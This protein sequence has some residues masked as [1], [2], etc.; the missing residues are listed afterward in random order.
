MAD[1]WFIVEYCCCWVD[2]RTYCAAFLV[3][4]VARMLVSRA[5]TGLI[6]DRQILHRPFHERNIRRFA[7]SMRST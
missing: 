7:R 6:E 3:T 1:F 5:P 4:R 2:I